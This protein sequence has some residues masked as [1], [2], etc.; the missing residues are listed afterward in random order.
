MISLSKHKSGSRN[1]GLM[2]K[3]IIQAAMILISVIIILPIFS[4]INFSF[5]TRTELFV[6]SPFSLPHN[7]YWDNYFNALYRLNIGTTFINTVAY[8]VISVIII[9]ILSGASAWVITRNRHKF[10]KFS[11]IY[12]LIGILIPFQALFLPIYIIGFKLQLVNTAYGLIFMYVATGISFGVF[13]MSSFI[14][15]VPIELEEAASI[16]GCSIFRTYFTIVMP[17][18]QPAIATLIIMQSFIIWNDY[19]LASLFVSSGNLK[20]LNV[21]F[22]QLFSSTASDY[23]TAMAGIV[24]TIIPIITLF[25]VLQ[26]YIVK[27]IMEGSLKG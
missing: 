13:V 19:L 9:V 16:D 10:Y 26:K 1:K 20:T 21:N 17:L 22:Q 23:S 6:S 5:K 11:Y 3:I 25:L 2:L 27:G 18:L 15:Q 7:L 12:Y 14:S 24:I 8:T 4:I